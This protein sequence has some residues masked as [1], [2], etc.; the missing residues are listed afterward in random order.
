MVD[1]HKLSSS[2]LLLLTPPCASCHPAGAGAPAGSLDERDPGG[3]ELLAQQDSGLPEEFRLVLLQLHIP[4]PVFSKG[5]PSLDHPP[6]IPSV[7]CRKHSRAGE[8]KLKAQTEKCSI[9]FFFLLDGGK[10][11]PE[12]T[13]VLGPDVFIL[14]N[15]KVTV[16]HLCFTLTANQM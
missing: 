9:P 1:E 13:R 7:P 6:P 12:L 11:R 16:G 3:Q 14:G 10:R 4:D 2:L 5:G 15:S 8:H